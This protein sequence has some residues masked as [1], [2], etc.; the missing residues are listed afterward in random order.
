MESKPHSEPTSK[1]DVS[2]L[3]A[4]YNRVELTRACLES[5]FEHAD[6]GMSVEIIVTDDCS[7]DGTLAFLNSLADRVRVISNAVRQCFG[8]NMNRA[9]IEARGEYLCLLN[10]DTEVT[11]GWLVKLLDAARRDP[12]IGVVG[13]LQIAPAT[14][15]IDHAGMVFDGELHA[16]HLYR[17]MD[18][19]Y[20][21]ARRTREFQMVTGAC[22]LV[23]RALFLELGGFDPI[24]K[25][26]CEDADFCLR[27][28]QHGRKVLYVGDSMIYHHGAS[29]PGR[30]DHE[31]SNL[32]KFY[33]KWDG[34]IRPD[35]ER[36][37]QDDRI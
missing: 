9:A 16:H 4:A 13:N 37:L 17:H 23:P 8:E 36:Y 18:P 33:Q 27:A 15:R 25:N 1:I 3:I 35:L 30:M 19:A 24:F 6:P 32:K 26:G 29:S 21:P 2:I 28:R 7:S 10:N 11:P 31:E 20:P 14:G 12:G 5:V 34:Q 22:W